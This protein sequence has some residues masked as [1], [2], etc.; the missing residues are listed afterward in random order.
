MEKMKHNSRQV[1]LELDLPEFKRR[2][3][4]IDLS[5]D[6]ALIRAEKKSEKKIKKKDFFQEE[7]TS[8]SFVYSTTLP[9]INPDLAKISFKGGVLKITAPKR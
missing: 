5:E 9:G 4:K 1:L 7:S 2:E 6:S 3:I 8:K